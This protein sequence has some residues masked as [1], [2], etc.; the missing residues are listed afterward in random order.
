MP[1]IECC[2]PH[3]ARSRIYTLTCLVFSGAILSVG[4]TQAGE[5]AENDELRVLDEVRV[6]AT[7]SSILLEDSPRALSVIFDDVIAERPGATGI[8]SM[9]AEIPGI[10]YARSGGLGGQI[11]MRGFNS[12]SMRSALVVDGD[13][14][15]GRSTLEFNMFDPNTIERIEVIRGP[16]SALWG[17]D[18]MNGVVNIVTRRARV[19]RN[20][21]FALDAKLRAIDYNSVNDLWATRAELIG[22][23]NGFDIL[24]GANLR[25]AD[26][27]ETPKGT[28]E[29]SGFETKGVDF[30]LGWSPT[31]DTRWELAGRF[32]D[33]RTERAGGLGA[34]PGA[35]YR[36]VTEDPI[37]ERHLKLGVES[38]N[39]GSFADWLE[40]SLYVR[41]WE[42]DI[43]HNDATAANGRLAPATVN[44]H[45]RVHSPTVTGGRLNANKTLGAHALAYGLDF[46]R[47][48]FEG[49]TVDIFRTNTATG[50][51]L[52]TVPTRKMERGSE[53]T[54]LGFFISNDWQVSPA[55]MLS[56]GLR[57]D[58]IRT[59]IEPAPVAG[60]S[61]AL[62]ALYARVR[63][64]TEKPLTGSMGAVFKL[65]PA[66]TATAQLSRGFRAPTGLERTI[67]ST[68]GTVVALPSPQ[69]DPERNTTVEAGLRHRAKDGGFGITAYRSEYEDLIQLAVVDATTRQRRNI[70]RAEITGLELDG[71]WRIA[72]HWTLRTAA[73]ATRATDT[74][75]NT[76]LE[77]V[78]EFVLRIAARYGADGPWYA[79]G[80]L[81]AATDR[82]RVNPATER[83]RAGYGL[84]DIY[85][86]V[87]LGKTFGA[88]WKDWKMTAGIEN[89][90]DRAVANQVAAEDLRY[91]QGLIGNPLMEP[92][93]ALVIKLVQDY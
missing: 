42:T 71:D 45:I 47:E 80:V 30:R 60:E 83:P 26:D 90:F 62:M 55:L 36:L 86:G 35:P 28:A 34:A 11:I 66:W 63:E 17:S 16:A 44:Q 76:P 64:T 93:R 9:L 50:A 79:E 23:G 59:E 22:G 57:W 81:R 7:R 5:I 4:E 2:R 92:G 77:G 75:S 10:S 32:Q 29:N 73:T 39:L 37:R 14:F 74:S 31:P 82:D 41:D 85:A 53:Q 65:N 61:A 87:D 12:N 38:R 33:V 40:G 24:V 58:Y 56:G 20:A 68:A 54:N 27:Y 49:R 1:H 6:E 8:Q 18:A 72:R 43:F 52:A 67:T 51:T 46:V 84:V 78:P 70:G 21:P 13:R 19:D 3:A 15:R 69:L 91:P 89:L 48:D 88:G 25:Q